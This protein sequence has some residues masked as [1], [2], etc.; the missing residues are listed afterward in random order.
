[1]SHNEKILNDKIEK[2]E[3][4]LKAMEDIRKNTLYSV[5]VL[6]LK[7]KQKRSGN[8]RL[9]RLI[10]ATECNSYRE[11]EFKVRF[12]ELEKQLQEMNDHGDPTL[13]SLQEVYATIDTLSEQLE[14]EKSDKR[15]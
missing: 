5:D 2:L 11:R 12:G 6:V 7:V 9:K 4:H 15:I 3:E 10:E 14:R 8:D 1:M 13:P